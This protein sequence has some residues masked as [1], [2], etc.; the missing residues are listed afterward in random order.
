MQFFKRLFGRGD[1]PAPPL[2]PASTPEQ[3]QVEYA[4]Q[5]EARASMEADVAR[6]RAKRGIVDPPPPAKTE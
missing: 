5:R 2:R 3:A 6:D 4:A 1:D